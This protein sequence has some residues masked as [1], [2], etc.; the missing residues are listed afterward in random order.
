LWDVDASR[1]STYSI[2]E[3][4][5]LLDVANPAL[6]G[7]Q[8]GG[9]RFVVLDAGIIALKEDFRK[10]FACYGMETS[11]LVM[12]GGEMAKSMN[13]VLT[14][15]EAF[16][17][18]GLDRRNEPVVIVGGGAVLD[19]AGFAASVFRRGVPFIRVPTTVLSYVD[20]SIGMKTGVNLNGRK[21]LL[22]AFAA[23]K[24]V[25]LDRQ[26]FE[27]LPLGEVASGLGEVLK[28]GVGCDQ[29]LFEMLEDKAE[30]FIADRLIGAK[31]L[32]LLRRAIDS[33]LEELR[34]NLFEDELRR[35]VDLGHTFSQPL[36]VK[37]GSEPLRHG[38]AVAVDL[39]LSAALA[40]RRG[41][42]SAA[43][44]ARL[45]RLTRRLQ[46]PVAPPHVPPSAFWSSVIDRT[47]HRAGR[48]RIPLPNGIGS[49]VFVDDITPG[50]LGEA[51]H[52]L[53]DVACP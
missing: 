40:C 34:R 21:N 39:N 22:G 3:A 23:P 12:A 13:V 47:R 17:Q 19:A 7:G 32:I 44:A 45:A 8:R 29:E 37:I 14:I 36:E 28:L 6:A 20:A 9:R 4:E 46:L 52:A 33:M 38:E 31:G 42:L 1:G 5:P 41:L 35:V 16:Q 15:A 51:L 18:F 43:D 10:Y 11:F 27:T 24:A 25:L 50:E 48:Q 26:F 30:S 53:R 2:V 49:C